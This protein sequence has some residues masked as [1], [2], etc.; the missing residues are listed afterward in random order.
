MV[1]GPV[2]RPAL[3][4]PGGGPDVPKISW[5]LSP[6]DLR[7]VTARDQLS[8]FQKSYGRKILARKPGRGQKPRDKDYVIKAHEQQARQAAKDLARQVRKFRRLEEG[9]DGQAL[10]GVRKSFPGRNFIVDSGASFN[11]V[12]YKSLSPAERT[13]VRKAHPISLNTANGMVD[14]EDVLDIYVQDLGI[15]IEF[16][17]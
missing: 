9:V 3:Q 11:L 13:R 6:A 8:T 15:T 16:Y 10:P 14:A 17:I 5:N 4:R 12:G 1:Y 7:S 2:I